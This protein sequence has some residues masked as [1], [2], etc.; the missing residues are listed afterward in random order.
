MKDARIVRLEFCH[1]DNSDYVYF[2]PGEAQPGTT[3]VFLKRGPALLF[4]PP[5]ADEC[6]RGLDAKQVKVTVLIEERDKP[7]ERY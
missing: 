3:L 1:V 5:L 7:V 4:N 6:F 2:R